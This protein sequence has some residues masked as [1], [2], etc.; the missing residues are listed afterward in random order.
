MGTARNTLASGM[1]LRAERVLV[2]VCK[3]YKLAVALKPLLPSVLYSSSLP[4]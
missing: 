4:I 3:T 1:V 2:I